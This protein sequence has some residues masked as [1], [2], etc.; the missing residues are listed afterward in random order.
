MDLGYHLG[1]VSVQSVL[2]FSTKLANRDDF[3]Y[4]LGCVSHT[5]GALLIP[6]PY[7]HPLHS[8]VCNWYASQDYAAHSKYNRGNMETR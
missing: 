8:N 7:L 4:R 2:S 3:G 6:L 5:V 1:Y